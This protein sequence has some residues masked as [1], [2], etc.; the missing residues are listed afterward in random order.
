MLHQLT[1]QVS[2]RNNSNNPF[3][4]KTPLTKLTDLKENHFKIELDN[5]EWLNFQKSIFTIV[6]D[7]VK[8]NLEPIEPMITKLENHMPHWTSETNDKIVYTTVNEAHSGLVDDVST[9]LIKL[10]KGFTNRKAE[11]S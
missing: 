9:F 3:T 4:N 5:K 10:K 11:I 6:S 1:S 7:D 2:F 8:G